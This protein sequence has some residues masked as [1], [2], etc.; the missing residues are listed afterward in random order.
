MDN[1]YRLKIANVT[2][3]VT[4]V[5]HTQNEY[6]IVDGIRVIG[7]YYAVELE[8]RRIKEIYVDSN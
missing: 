8:T 7:T 4:D 2:L 3:Q 1:L 5:N 6:Q